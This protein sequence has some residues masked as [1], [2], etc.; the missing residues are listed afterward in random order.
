MVLELCPLCPPVRPVVAENE[1]WRLVL[2]ENQATL[3]RVY[4]AL[5]RHET[6][7][8]ALAP[9]E[10]LSLWQFAGQAKRALE[11]VFAPDHF[12]YLFHMN[13]TPHVHM[14]IYPRY[15]APRAFAGQTF[16]DMH[17]GDHYDPQE[18]HTLDAVTD[19]LLVVTL[20]QA[21]GTQEDGE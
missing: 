2:N 13:L 20:R 7:A 21:M 16:T 17:F 19:N 15:Q 6:D 5:K 12:N 3:G 4:F 9:D 10:V 18:V 11:N 8:A 1:H 14:H